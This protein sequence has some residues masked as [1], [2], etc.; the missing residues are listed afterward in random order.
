M[1]PT[2][3]QPA[4]KENRGSVSHERRSSANSEPA[5]PRRKRQRR[6]NDDL[7]GFPGGGI[8][9]AAFLSAASCFLSFCLPLHFCHFLLN[10]KATSQKLPTISLRSLGGSFLGCCD[11]E[12]SRSSWP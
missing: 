10:I 9:T 4:S 1:S 6:R 8:A 3:M 7:D 12:A 11:C 5:S 2:D